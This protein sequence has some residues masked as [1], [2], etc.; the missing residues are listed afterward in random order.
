MSRLQ[1]K[2]GRKSNYAKSLNNDYH[3][4]LRRKVMLRDNFACKLCGSKLF[5]E[6]HHITYYQN[7]ISIVGNELEFM[8]WLVMLCADCHQLVHN[9]KSHKFN[10]NNP[11]KKQFNQ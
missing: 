7:G 8:G 1:H 3:K 11:L 4:E 6:M 5:L 9:D 10:P 2:K